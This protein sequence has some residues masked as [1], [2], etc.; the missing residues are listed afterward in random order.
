MAAWH[1]WGDLDDLA[2]AAAALYAKLGRGATLSEL[3]TRQPRAAVGGEKK[4]SGNISRFHILGLE[5]ILPMISCDLVCFLYYISFGLS[6]I[7]WC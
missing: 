4:R 6:N 5:N 1:R 3:L 2:P 7:S